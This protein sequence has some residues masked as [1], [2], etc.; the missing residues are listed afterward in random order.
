MII[1]KIA[2]II[3]DVNLKY[4]ENIIGDHFFINY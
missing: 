1:V 2:Q 3:F 4:Y